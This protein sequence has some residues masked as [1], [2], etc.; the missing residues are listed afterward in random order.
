ML[1][2]TFFSFSDDQQ[3]K[4]QH[5]SEKYLWMAQSGSC[6]SNVCISVSGFFIIWDGHWGV[7][8]NKFSSK[9]R[10]FHC[11]DS[12]IL[13]CVQEDDFITLS[14]AYFRSFQNI[15]KLLQFHINIQYTVLKCHFPPFKWIF[16]WSELPINDRW[17]YLSWQHWF[18]KQWYFLFF[19]STFVDHVPQRSF[20]SDAQTHSHSH[21]GP[22]T[23]SRMVYGADINWR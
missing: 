3:Q 2:L 19:F 4:W 9:M 12:Y 15:V 17:K 20:R 16:E 8:S 5:N 11:R 23:R 1:T 10:L 18:F 22:C 7:T 6:W 21:F 14:L 13:Q